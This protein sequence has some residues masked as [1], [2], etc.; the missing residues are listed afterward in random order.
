MHVDAATHVCA[1]GW[2]GGEGVRG[3]DGRPGAQQL[4]SAAAHEMCVRGV[5]RLMRMQ[6]AG[7]AAR[8]CA[9][10]TGDQEYSNRFRLQP[11]RSV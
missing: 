3:A 6:A 2:R 9:A 8:G 11:M 10:L 1:G 7:G 4:L 5:M